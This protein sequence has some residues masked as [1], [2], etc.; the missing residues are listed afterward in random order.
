MSDIAQLGISVETGD[1][2]AAVVDL[3]KMADASVQ[4][5]SAVTRL[6]SASRASAAGTE[7]A[8]ATS[9][10]HTAA[11]QAE[12]AATRMVAND[13]RM[14]GF[15]IND[16]VVS[17]ASGMNPAMVALQQGSQISQI[18][19]R[20]LTA[21]IAPMAP[22]LLAV[23]AAVGVVALGFAGM[24]TEINKN[25]AVQVSWLGVTKATF[26]VAWDS[27]QR[28]AQPVVGWFSKL[29]ST[30]S[31]YVSD[32]AVGMIKMFDLGFRDIKT[33]F[34]YLPAAIAEV[35]LR[36][37]N[38]VITSIQDMINKAI[39]LLNTTFIDPVQAG[40]KNIG[41]EIGH[42]GKVDFGKGL[43][44]P[45]NGV[46]GKMQ[47]ELQANLKDVNSTDYLGIIGDRAAAD[48]VAAQAKATDALSKSMRA[49]NDNAK[50]LQ[51]GLKGV[52]GVTDM[53]AAS[54][55]AMAETALGAFGQLAGGLS[56]LFK[57]NKEIALASAVIN[58]AE[59]ITKALGQGGIFGFVGAAG[60]AAAGAAQIASIL[61]AQPGSASSVAVSSGAGSSASLAAAAPAQQGT[62]I[63]LTI[64]GS[65]NVNV[66]DFAS[67]LAQSISDGGNQRLVKVIRAA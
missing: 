55:K 30:I 8:T 20:G 59:G 22:L 37:V 12:A 34:S 64:R 19:I 46:G 63:N 7:M 41:I 61:S 48:Q 23:G 16:I 54:Q 27:F 38:G 13:T 42:I 67:Q 1:L 57:G 62:S 18:G 24:T 60:V 51:A 6:G 26:E 53:V 52:G 29:W 14:L 39:D 10:L 50:L 21:A 17:L 3:D 56:Q 28:F 47:A 32:T 25:Q 4:A 58:V 9:R 31:P 5:E 44:N 65:G 33:I 15:Q 36:T 40:L 49:A 35:M 11:L 45:A 66:D 2:K 43:P